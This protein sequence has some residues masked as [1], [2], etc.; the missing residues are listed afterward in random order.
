MECTMEWMVNVHRTAKS[1]N[2]GCTACS[3]WEMLE[4][5]LYRL[6]A[7]LGF[8]AY[9]FVVPSYTSRAHKNLCTLVAYPQ[10]KCR[11]VLASLRNGII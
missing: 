8:K 9:L 10:Y 7:S 4:L 11:A 3:V 1:C 6:V 2:S 5:V